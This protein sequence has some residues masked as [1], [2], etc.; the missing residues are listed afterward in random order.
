MT[1]LLGRQAM[2]GHE[3]PMYLRSMMATRLP[4]EAKVQAARVAP[5]PPPRIT[6]SNS[7]NSASPSTSEDKDGLSMVFMRFFPSRQP[8]SDMRHASY[9]C[10]SVCSG[11]NGA[12]PKLTLNRLHHTE[13]VRYFDK[14]TSE[15]S[16]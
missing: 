3:P 8:M 16:T 1:F 11:L 9:S 15:P 4:S 5:V 6:I 7:S 14:S 2:L 13:T 10:D 12:A